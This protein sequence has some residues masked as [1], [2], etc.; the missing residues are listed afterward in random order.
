MIKKKQR[1]TNRYDKNK[2]NTRGTTAL[3]GY[4]LGAGMQQK[5]HNIVNRYERLEAKWKNGT[6]NSDTRFLK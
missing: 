1:K 3:I 5:F 2:N 4:L 6:L